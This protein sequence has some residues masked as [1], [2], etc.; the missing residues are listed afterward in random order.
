MNK[1]YFYAIVGAAIAV[2]LVIVGYALHSSTQVAGSNAPLQGNAGD[3][4][5][6][7]KV[8]LQVVNDTAT[9]TWYSVLNTDSNDRVLVNYHQFLSGITNTSFSQATLRVACATST[10]PYSI[11]GGGAATSSN[12]VLGWD[13]ATSSAIQYLASSTPGK[14]SATNGINIWAAGTYLNCVAN[15]T[16]TGAGVIGFSYLPE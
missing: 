13:I 10:D 3:T 6:T 7:A 14:I 16:S 15:A 9:T 4:F 11:N 12:L 5:N 8:A 2:G 1:N